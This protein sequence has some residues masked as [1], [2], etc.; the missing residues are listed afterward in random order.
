MQ[1]WDSWIQKS[2]NQLG[3]SAVTPSP[4][5]LIPPSPTS[6][7]D[8]QEEQLKLRQVIDNKVRYGQKPT[9][10]EYVRARQ[11]DAI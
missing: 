11:I 5:G 7:A 2:T 6:I 9:D 1:P 4:S 8:Q 3:A 10:A